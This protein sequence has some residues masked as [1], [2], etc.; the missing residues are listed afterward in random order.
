MSYYFIMTPLFKNF[1]IAC[2][3]GG[4]RSSGNRAVFPANHETMESKSEPLVGIDLGT[5]SCSIGIVADGEFT[6]VPNEQG[7]RSTPSVVAFE[8]TEAI[9][10]QQ[11]VDISMQFPH[12]TVGSVKRLLGSD[13]VL[14]TG[15]R[16]FT[17]EEVTAL[18]LKK[19]VQDAERAGHTIDSAVLTVPAGFTSRQRRST[20]RA[21]EIAGLDIERIVTDPTAASLAYGLQTG[22]SGTVLVYD[23]G[24]GRCDVSLI[25]LT[26]G[27]CEVIATDGREIGGE[28]YDSAIVRWLASQIEYEHDIQLRED[29]IA[30]QRLFEAARTAK[31]ELSDRTT[32][33]IE[34]PF[35]PHGTDSYEIDYRLHRNQFERLVRDITGRT[36]SLCEKLLDRVG[37]PARR[38][39]E[40]LLVGGATQS[41]HIRDRFTQAFGRTPTTEFDPVETVPFGATAE[42]A[43]LAHEPIPEPHRSVSLTPDDLVVI[44]VAPH[45]IVVSGDHPLV[46]DNAHIPIRARHTVTP[47]EDWQKFVRFP[48]WYTSTNGPDSSTKDDYDRSFDEEFRIGPLPPRPAA[49]SNIDIEFELDQNGVLQAST[50]E[51]DYRGNEIRIEPISDF[52]PK[53]IRSMGSKLPNIR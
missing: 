18:V 36:V 9:V 50:S 24:G 29:S 48:I 5:T 40:I 22:R 26:D 34:I 6:V 21:G 42:A 53:Q 49:L 47:S 51:V 33:T 16:E 20:M 31:H 38:L 23:L 10:G 12:R 37:Y 27:V 44:D 2:G 39:D 28:D 14:D 25:E 4:R 7:D 43:I 35:L 15:T 41:P 11:A 52:T 17:P 32:T 8:G 46:P 19:V 3:G 13:R 1:F 30:V 45:E